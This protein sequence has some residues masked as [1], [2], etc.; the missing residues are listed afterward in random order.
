MTAYAKL[1]KTIWIFTPAVDDPI[2]F[3][4]WF[5]S[6]WDQYS[7]KF[8]PTARKL[9][10][11]SDLNTYLNAQK[12]QVS[13]STCFYFYYPQTM[14]E[15]SGL[16]YP[17]Q[18]FYHNMASWLIK[19]C[20]GSKLLL[21]HSF[22]PILDVSCSFTHSGNLK[23]PWVFDLSAQ[24][25]QFV[26]VTSGWDGAYQRAS[27]PLSCERK[28]HLTTSLTRLYLQ[29]MVETR[30]DLIHLVLWLKHYLLNLGFPKEK[31]LNIY[32]SPA[33]P[34][35]LLGWSINTLKCWVWAFFKEKL[36]LRLYS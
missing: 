9:E 7:L 12:N 2:W 5:L 14:Q 29:S 36:W 19:N 28:G 30:G 3:Q 15:L 32:F 17:P 8:S 34:D 11:I 33:E 18:M 35:P 21:Y 25:P 22:T 4:V 31:P 6:Y 26:D 10:F 13:R 24:R 1:L 27:K 23:A 16:F 20:M